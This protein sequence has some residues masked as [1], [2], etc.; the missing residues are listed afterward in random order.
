MDTKQAA[1]YLAVTQG[2]IRV[3]D[4]RGYLVRLNRGESPAL[5]LRRDLDECETDRHDNRKY[6]RSTKP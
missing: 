5:Y 6:R 4:H 2:Q 3:W 1:D